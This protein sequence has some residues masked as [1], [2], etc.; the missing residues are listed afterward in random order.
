[1]KFGHVDLLTLILSLRHWSQAREQALG[2][3]GTDEPDAENVL[4]I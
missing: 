2:D 1:L 3:E 4:N